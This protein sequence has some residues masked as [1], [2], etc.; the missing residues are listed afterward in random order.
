MDKNLIRILYFVEVVLHTLFRKALILGYVDVV[1]HTLFRKAL[2]LGYH[3]RS[4]FSPW[5]SL[6]SV[7]QVV[8]VV[9]HKFHV[10]SMFSTPHVCILY[11]KHE[12]SYSVL[13]PAH[14]L[15]LRFLKFGKVF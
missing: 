1:L 2:I 6:S 3:F 14:I 13:E 9:G 7:F 8:Y 11:D 15:N 4:D 5:Y 12:D 10:T